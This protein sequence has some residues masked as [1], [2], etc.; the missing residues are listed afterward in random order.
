LQAFG[1]C[2]VQPKARPAPVQA[3]LACR[4][5]QP[6]HPPTQWIIGPACSANDIGEQ[7]VVVDVVERSGQVGI[8]N[9]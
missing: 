8:E 9:P 5:L 6:R 3:L 4:V 7:S 1:F 2:L